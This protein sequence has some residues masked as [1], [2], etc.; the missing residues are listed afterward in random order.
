MNLVSANIAQIVRGCKFRTSVGDGVENGGDLWNSKIKFNFVGFHYTKNHPIYTIMVKAVKNALISVFHKEGLDELL[1]VLKANGTHIYSTGGTYQYLLEKGMDVSTVEALTTYPSILGGRVK[2]LHP[3]VFGGILGR[4]EEAQDVAEMQ[5]YGMPE[6]DMVVV[7]LYP[8][9]QTVADGGSE[10]EIIEKIDIGGVSLIRAAAKNFKDVLIVPSSKSYAATADILRRQ[11]GATLEQRAAAAAEAIAETAAYDGLISQ[12][13]LS[14]YAEGGAARGAAELA[15]LH[16]PVGE[17]A[18]RYGENPHQKGYFKGKL[19]DA[20]TQLHGKEISYNNLLDIHAAF[21]LIG[22]FALPQGQTPAGNAAAPYAVAIIKHSNPCGFAVRGS[23]KEAYETALAC[24]PLSAFGGVVVCNAPVDLPTATAMNSLFIEVLIAPG[25]APEALQLLQS[26]KNRVILQVSSFQL[27]PYVLRSCVNGCLVQERDTRVDEAAGNKVVTKAQPSEKELRDLH[28]ANI[29]VKHCKSNAIVLA[30][31]GQLLAAG[32]GQTSRVDA[33]KQAI[34]KAQRFGFELKG[35]VLA[36]DAF[37]P[38]SDC[39]EIASQNGIEAFI[40]PGG[41][42]RDQ[43]SVQYCD[44]HGL[45]MV[46]TGL[47]HFRH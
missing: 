30:K 12:W 41:S 25:Y 39:V 26:K 17:T 8:F 45:K 44:E 47:R 19:S 37:F 40:Q 11:G 22:E 5:Q 35:A 9:A 20:F 28:F 33:L 14:R 43:D 13:M 24:D 4:R 38:F 6:I 18:L 42:V 10:A 1:A 2:T 15:D 46:F 36:S 7:D 31:D 29:L 16:L 32:V 34:E 21:E 23:L 27:P 3:M